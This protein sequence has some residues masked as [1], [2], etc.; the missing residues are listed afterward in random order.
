MQPDF[1][2]NDLV[3]GLH[4]NNREAFNALYNKYCTG[5]R[6]NIGKLIYKYEVAEDILQEVF[7]ALWNNRL[8]IDPSQSVAGWLFVV[9][10]HK[11]LKWLKADIREH[12][13]LQHL[14]VLLKDN[15]DVGLKETT[16]QVQLQILHSAISELPFRKKQAFQLCKMEGKTY[17]EAGKIL[18]ISTNTV[19]EYVKT[20]TQSIRQSVL[21][22]KDYSSLIAVA[23]LAV[24]LN[25]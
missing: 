17:E 5:V 2:D 9:S 6:R 8:A 3:I 7:L 4:N 1:E 22:K 16:F 19:Q 14:P 20:S 25:L 24:F 15:E 10:Y 23:G 18:G 11:S 21:S 13:L 12:H